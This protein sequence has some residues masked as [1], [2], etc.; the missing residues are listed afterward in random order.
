MA[1][2]EL[3]GQLVGKTYAGW[4]KEIRDHKQKD[5]LSYRD[6][7]MKIESAYAEWMRETGEK[8]R[9]KFA[10]HLRDD[11]GTSI[12]EGMCLPNA[13][14]RCWSVS[15]HVMAY[16]SRGALFDMH[17]KRCPEQVRACALERARNERNVSGQW[18]RQKIAEWW[19]K[20]NGLPPLCGPRIYTAVS[21]LI[22]K[23]VELR[24]GVNMTASEVYAEDRRMTGAKF[25]KPR[26]PKRKS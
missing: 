21:D 1:T 22:I 15:P 7:G 25:V 16:V 26:K 3:A 19:R 17:T 23:T 12:R 14:R 8:S 6:L 10:I 11:A 20:Q 13:V 18:V 2:K 4:C 24:D 5:W 9:R